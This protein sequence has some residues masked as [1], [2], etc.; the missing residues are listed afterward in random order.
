MQR[1]HDNSAAAANVISSFTFPAD[2]GTGI[3]FALSM[4]S[5]FMNPAEFGPPSFPPDLF[6]GASLPAVQSGSSALTWDLAP[7]WLPQLAQ[8]GSTQWAEPLVQ[9][10]WDFGSTCNM[11]TRTPSISSSTGEFLDAAYDIQP[12]PTRSPSSSSAG[13]FFEDGYDIDLLMADMQHGYSSSMF[14][15]APPSSTPDDDGRLSRASSVSIKISLW[16]SGTD[17]PAVEM[18]PPLEPDGEAA[19]MDSRLDWDWKPSVGRAA[20][21]D[22]AALQEELSEAKEELTAARSEAK[23][24]PSAEA[25]GRAEAKSSS[26]GRVRAKCGA[27]ASTSKV[28]AQPA[29]PPSGLEPAPS[30]TTLP[31]E[32]LITAAPVAEGSSDVPAARKCVQADPSDMAPMSS[33]KRQKKLV[34]PLAGWGMEDPDTGE[35]LTGHEWVRRYLEEFKQQYKKDHQCYLEYLAQLADS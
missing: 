1:A 15:S 23:A 9:P 28:A 18:A 29:Q 8:Q 27:A 17:D 2:S 7:S 30:T 34:D 21:A 31:S 33:R 24:E 32:L 5:P 6:P 25:A 35:Q 22:V 20:D 13:E 14:S 11:R 3:D 10:H 19:D 16:D 26:S 12:V 4:V